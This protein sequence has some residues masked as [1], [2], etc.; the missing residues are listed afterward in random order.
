MLSGLHRLLIQPAQSAGLLKGVKTLIFVPHSS[1]AYLPF[2][3]LVDPASGRY[4]VEQ[5][6]LTLIPSAASFRAVRAEAA[7]AD[8]RV[9]DGSVFAP[10][11]DELPGTRAEVGAVRGHEIG[12]EQSPQRNTCAAAQIFIA[13]CGEPPNY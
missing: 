3:A 12:F 7:V 13:R 1:L 8:R 9:A 5:Y 2:A 4:L 10:F 6:D 11:P